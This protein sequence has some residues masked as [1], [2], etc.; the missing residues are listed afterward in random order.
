M[1]SPA[2]TVEDVRL[3]DSD[4]GIKRLVARDLAKFDEKYQAVL[5]NLNMKNLRY[6]FYG[7]SLQTF[8]QTVGTFSGT[9]AG[10]TAVN[11]IAP[12]P[13]GELMKLRTAYRLPYEYQYMLSEFGCLGI[14]P[15]VA[16]TAVSSTTFTVTLPTSVNCSARFEV[17]GRI[18][19]FSN[20][21]SAANTEYIITAVSGSGVSA[22]ITVA[23]TKGATASGR[24]ALVEAVALTDVFDFTNQAGG[25]ATTFKIANDWTDVFAAGKTF[26]CHSNATAAVNN[27]QAELAATTSS[28]NQLSTPPYWTVL[29]VAFATGVTTITVAAM[30]GTAT[31]TGKLVPCAV[32]NI[33]YQV[34]DMERGIIRTLSTST[35]LVAL[36]PVRP[37]YTLSSIASGS[38]LLRPQTRQG[39]FEGNVIVEWS[40]GNFAQ[41]TVREFRG[42]MT[43]GAGS[44][45][46]SQFSTFPL[47]IE[48]LTD[49]TSVTNPAGRLLNYKGALPSQS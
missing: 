3:E 48:V 33:D 2:N 34:V 31:A 16:I 14:L 15:S 38:R 36:Q 27:G 1:V 41:R 23:D 26:F 5:Y 25:A 10:V 13:N 22:V 39:V 44:F 32:E 18:R 40:R 45:S 28:S 24:L 30:G 9:P 19:V 8:G 43:P 47:D 21:T 46:D 12:S 7:D 37:V 49:V 42:S 29:S 20:A 17:G 35:Q 6:L 4:G 11:Q